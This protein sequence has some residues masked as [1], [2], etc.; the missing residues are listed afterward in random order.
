MRV[1]IGLVEPRDELFSLESES[2]VQ[3]L[4]VHVAIVRINMWANTNE[5]TYHRRTVGRNVEG[6]VSM[7]MERDEMVQH[8]PG[9]SR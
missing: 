7:R 9:G 6:D 5:D 3:Q 4:A 2:V 8:R 1:E